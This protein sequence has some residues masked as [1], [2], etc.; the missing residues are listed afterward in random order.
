[1]CKSH[2]NT[3]ISRMHQVYIWAKSTVRHTC[4]QSP[5]ETQ[6]M[7]WCIVSA[8]TNG[9]VRICCSHS[10]RL[11]RAADLAAPRT[12]NI[13][14][15][16]PERRVGAKRTFSRYCVSVNVHIVRGR[17][18][19]ID[20]VWCNFNSSAAPLIGK[21]KRRSSLYKSEVYSIRRVTTKLH[22]R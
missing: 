2:T 15:R 20:H 10:S 17:E 3:H 6:D 1:M 14:L 9:F 11:Y 4:S 16:E 8:G 21:N 5:A 12:P 7:S 13:V 19:V 22:A 18:S